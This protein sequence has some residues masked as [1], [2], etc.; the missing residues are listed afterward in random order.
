MRLCFFGA[1]NHEYP[2][3]TV[4][5]KG[6]R[7]NGVEVSECWLPPKYKFWLRYPLLASKYLSSWA[8]HDSLFVPEFCQ[9][10]VPLAKILSLFYSKKVVFDPLA[11]RFETKIMDWKR[12]PLD[13]W[14]ARLNFKI[15]YCLKHSNVSSR[16]EAINVS[17]WGVFRNSIAQVVTRIQASR[18]V[19]ASSDRLPVAGFHRVAY[20]L[21]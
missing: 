3:N 4:I 1:Y 21:R 12:K 5:K 20:F 18:P 8:K 13:S 16:V 11:G 14:Q 15:D 19:W 10:D 2:R 7:L 9:K 17:R 6:L